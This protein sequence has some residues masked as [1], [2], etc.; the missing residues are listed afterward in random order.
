MSAAEQ[1]SD[2]GEAAICPAHEFAGYSGRLDGLPFLNPLV[3]GTAV[4]SQV[5]TGP[6]QIA[7]TKAASGLIKIEHQVRA[8]E[9]KMAPVKGPFS[10]SLTSHPNDAGA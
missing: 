9:K 3:K 1:E 7:A 2:L 4:T 10:Y 5:W 8:C 6:F